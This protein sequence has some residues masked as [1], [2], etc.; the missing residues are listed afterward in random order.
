MFFKAVLKFKL[1]Q[2]IIRMKKYCFRDKNTLIY[3]LIRFYLCS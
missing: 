3:S 2:N 1:R